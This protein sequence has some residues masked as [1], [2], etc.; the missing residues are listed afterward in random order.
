MAVNLGTVQASTREPETRRPSAPASEADLVIAACAGDEAAF[1]ELYREG[2]RAVVHILYNDTKDRVKAE[3][4]SQWAWVRAW[5]KRHQYRP[6]HTFISWVLKIAR[7]HWRDEMRRQNRFL[8]IV[9]RGRDLLREWT[10]SNEAS[11]PSAAAFE[12][13]RAIYLEAMRALKPE[14]RKIIELRELEE[15]SYA[16]IAELLGCPKGTVMS[17]LSAAR[18]HLFKLCQ[19]KSNP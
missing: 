5:E 1:A 17:R 6:E 4:L 9:D 10:H 14:H 8:A 12:E 19:P 15:Y 16:Q 11:D 13:R 18:Q 2:Y 7:N 3:E